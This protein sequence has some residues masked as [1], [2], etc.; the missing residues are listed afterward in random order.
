MDEKRAHEE[1]I[2]PLTRHRKPPTLERGRG[3]ATYG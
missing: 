2:S 1:A 3:R